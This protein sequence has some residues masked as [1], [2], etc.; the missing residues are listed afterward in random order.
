MEGEIEILK[1]NI[2][3][4]TNQLNATRVALNKLGILQG[5]DWSNDLQD[6][7]SIKKLKE[8]KNNPRDA[9]D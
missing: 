2:G 4:L 3:D 5:L 6:W 7:V 1:R 9:K 8:F